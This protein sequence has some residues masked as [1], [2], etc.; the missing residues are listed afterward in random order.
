LLADYF[1]HLV[2]NGE[3]VRSPLIYES[4]RLI[5][6]P[7][8]KSRNAIRSARARLLGAMV[9]WGINERL[10]F[11][12]TVIETSTLSSYVEMTPL[13]I[14]LGLS[15]PYGGGRQSPGGG[16]C[17]AV[18]WPMSQQV[19]DDIRAYAGHDTAHVPWVEIGRGGEMPVTLH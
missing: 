4:T 11:M 5:V 19:L 16:D 1:A 2:E 13:T 6:T 7:R 15:H 9:E 14:P 8:E 17:M 10:T 3:P 12:Q 18:R